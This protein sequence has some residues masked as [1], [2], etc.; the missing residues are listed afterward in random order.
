MVSRN[1]EG[2]RVR[3]PT[4][5]IRL[6]VFPSFV[7]FEQLQFSGRKCKDFEA[8]FCCPKIEQ[9]RRQKQFDELGKPESEPELP[10]NLV[11]KITFE[12]LRN[13]SLNLPIFLSENIFGYKV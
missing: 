1:F 9:S 12:E 7:C 13:D 11:P 2:I 4:I 8:R 3:Y 5:F 10:Y 6:N